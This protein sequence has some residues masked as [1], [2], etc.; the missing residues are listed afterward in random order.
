MESNPIRDEG[1]NA[2]SLAQITATSC[3]PAQGTVSAVKSAKKV[4]D[5]HVP[6]QPER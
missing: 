2:A 5:A 6:V 3:N 4:V 1:P